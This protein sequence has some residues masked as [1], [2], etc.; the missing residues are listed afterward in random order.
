MLSHDPNVHE[1]KLHAFLGGLHSLWSLFLLLITA[2][3]FGM[4]RGCINNHKINVLVWTFP[5]NIK[6]VVI[7]C[8]FFTLCSISAFMEDRK[9]SWHWKSCFAPGYI[10]QNN[11]LLSIHCIHNTYLWQCTNLYLLLEPRTQT[12]KHR[13]M[14][15]R[16]SKQRRIN[17]SG[18]QDKM[19]IPEAPAI[20]VHTNTYTYTPTHK[21]QQKYCVYPINADIRR[22][23]CQCIAQLLTL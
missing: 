19:N 1:D 15:N 5:L 23:C 4:P 20:N 9:M 11:F 13:C 21:L 6:K 12:D 16:C 22:R 17:A 3:R 7:C 10:F 2:Y 14:L 8:D 18:K